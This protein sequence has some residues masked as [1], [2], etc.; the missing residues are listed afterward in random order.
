MRNKITN[1][2]YQL[3]NLILYGPIAD[4]TFPVCVPKDPRVRPA[5]CKH[6]HER[7]LSS[8]QRHPLF[9]EYTN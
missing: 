4:Y 2:Y 9:P 7:N 6:I 1:N 5:I 8:E 3:K